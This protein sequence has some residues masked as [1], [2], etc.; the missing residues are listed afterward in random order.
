MLSREQHGKR[1][2]ESGYSKGYALTTDC[3]GILPGHALQLL[4]YHLEVDE[5][6]EIIEIGEL[7]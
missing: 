7:S 6:L 4:R 2:S 1:I 5:A 3:L